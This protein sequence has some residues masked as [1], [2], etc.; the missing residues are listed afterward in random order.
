MITT[1]KEL[2]LYSKKYNLIFK[3]YFHK[4]FLLGLKKK[5]ENNLEM[6]NLE[7]KLGLEEDQLQLKRS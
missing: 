7:K 1:L 4:N 3:K 5:V 6:E 2:I